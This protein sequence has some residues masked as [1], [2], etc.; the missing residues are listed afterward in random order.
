VD[1]NPLNLELMTILLESEG[2]DVEPVEDAETA[3]RKIRANRPD[4]LVIDVQLPGISGLDLLRQVRSEPQTQD[5]C[6]VVVTSYAMSSDEE[7]AYQAGCDGYIRKPIDT[8]TFG[9]QVREFQAG[10]RVKRP[11]TVEG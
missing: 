6:A 1:D 4:L 5:I 10:Q 7:M 9:Q 3:L 2:F 11:G 8:R